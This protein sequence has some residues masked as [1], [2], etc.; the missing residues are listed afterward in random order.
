MCDNARRP[1]PPRRIVLIKYR[2]R[3][4]D[5]DRH[6]FEIDCRIDDP[7]PEQRFT[8]PAWIPGSYLLREFARFVVSIEASSGGRA[9]PVEKTESSAWLVTIR[10]TSRARPCATMRAGQD[11]CGESP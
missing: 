1:R 4:A 9:L 3:V 5:L 7:T 11:L 10:A 8:L 6:L 2:V